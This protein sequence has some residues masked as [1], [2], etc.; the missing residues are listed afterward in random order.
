MSG[1]RKDRINGKR[2]K[3]LRPQPQAAHSPGRF[4]YV[5][6]SL[7][8]HPVAATTTITVNTTVDELNLLVM[9]SAL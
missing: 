9:A 8:P 7:S 4:F 6:G 2:G 5:S 1:E 3:F